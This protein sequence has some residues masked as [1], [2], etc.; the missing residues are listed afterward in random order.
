MYAIIVGCGRVGSELAMLLSG[1]GHE[2]TIID[3]VGSSF[4]HLDPAWRGR[5]IEAEAMAEGVLERAGVARADAL[6]SVTNSDAVNAVVA[7][8][9]LTVYRVPSVVSRNYDPR[10]RPLHEAMGLRTV[11]STAWGAQRVEELLESRRVRP[12]FSAGNGEVELYELDV[13]PAWESRPL[14]ELVD[15]V[16]C[17]VMSLTHAGRAALAG[18]DTALHAGDLIHVGASLDGAGQL[19]A[20]LYGTE[21]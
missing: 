7:H 1:R 2:V 16:P 9:A 20:R 13:P 15:G 19:R 8:V 21:A 17:T 4:S 14:S 11:S 12:V 5:T 10:W 18:R 6:A 3:H